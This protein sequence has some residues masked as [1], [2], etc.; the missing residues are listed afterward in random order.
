MLGLDRSP[1]RL[2]DHR[3]GLGDED[4]VALGLELDHV[5]THAPHHEV[6]HS[7][8]VVG[9]DY[10]GGEAAGGVL[11]PRTPRAHQQ[12]GVH[13]PLGGARRSNPTARS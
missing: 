5:G 6:L 8:V 4:L 12:V 3:L 11:Q 10:L 1:V 9:C 13:G 7:L 2:A